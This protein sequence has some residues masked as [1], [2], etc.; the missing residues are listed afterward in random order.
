MIALPQN[1]DSADSVEKGASGPLL[2]QSTESSMIAEFAQA[3]ADDLHR[4]VCLHD[5]ELTPA[6]MAELR[7]SARSGPLA[8]QL[9]VTL[10]GDEACQALA[11]FQEALLGLPQ[12]DDSRSLDLLAVDYAAIYLNHTL[13]AYPAESVW[14]DDENLVRQEPMLQVQKWY[15]RYYLENQDPQKRT[16]DHLVH[17]LQFIAYLLQQA[18]LPGAPMTRLLTDAATFMDEH[19]LRWLKLFATRVAQRCATQ[20]YA[21]LALTTF[22]Y[23][24]EVRDLL[25]S[26][27][28]QPR[29]SPEMVEERLNPKPTPSTTGNTGSKKIGKVT[30]TPNC[31]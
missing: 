17:E 8:L 22:A 3:V 12:P 25:A 2:E 5:Q 11:F 21:G 28:D 30:F 19:P 26:L 24:D 15:Q 7:E 9:A 27:L 23:L 14:L 16:E 13:R 20:F 4:F 31:G 1:D 10:Q 18:A 6:L 29:P